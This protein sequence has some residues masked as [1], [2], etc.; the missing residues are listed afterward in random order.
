MGR[1]IIRRLLQSVG[2]LFAILALSFLLMNLAPGGP[3]RIYAEDPRISAAVIKDI[4]ERLGL[5]DPLPIQFARWAWSAIRLDFGT[6]FVEKRAVFGLVVDAAINTLWLTLGGTLL[7]FLGIP[8]GIWAARRRGKFADNAVRVVTVLLNSMP[9]WWLCLLIIIVVANIAAGGGPKL[10]PLG[11]MYAVG[12]EGNILNRLH[13]LVLPSIIVSLGYIIVFS[14]FARSQTLEV[15]GQDYVRT[16]R[17]K[18]LPD[19]QV[20]RWHVLRNS[21][22]PLITIMGGILPSLFGG[23]VLTE[24]VLAWPGMG[25][26][27]LN[28]ASQR[29]Y[30]VL[31]GVILF[32]AVLVIIGNLLA[33][34][35]YGLV[36]PRV[37]YN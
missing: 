29:D 24:R 27:F 11:S 7:G 8:L 12:Q 20:N 3:L 9:H 6:S 21:L 28:A 2:L 32:S 26:L 30:P 34:L 10:V 13:H 33:D 5:R 37:R 22:I 17:A 16:A 19:G 14:R 23:L 35:A 25:T 18:G 31:M 36:D 1:F 4:E 15:L